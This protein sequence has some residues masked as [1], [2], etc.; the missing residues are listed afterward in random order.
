MRT[1]HEVLEELI[2]LVKFKLGDLQVDLIHKIIFLSFARAGLSLYGST[3]IH[4]VELENIE[5]STISP[6]YR[7]LLK[8]ELYPKALDFNRSLR[9]FL[10]NR[11]G[12]AILEDANIQ[13]ILNLLR[14]RVKRVDGVIALD[15]GSIPEII[16]IT[17]KLA[18][19]NRKV[20]VYDFFVNPAGVTRF[21]TN[22]LS[23]F[24]RKTTLKS[25]SELLGE[26]LEARFN[27]KISVIDLTVHERGVDLKDFLKSLDITKIFNQI[28]STRGSLVITADHGY[29]LVADEY[30]LYLTHGYRGECPLNFS[31][32]APFIVVD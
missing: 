2:D 23:T 14:E 20:T 32:I 27:I 17:G 24:G 6:L 25:Y 9:E 13:F 7:G 26:K 19:L 16:A 30:G 18:Y 3:E 12:S 5:K 22:Q 10:K 4:K 29:D 28:A 1:P 11:G 21:L 31:K 15:G 8:G